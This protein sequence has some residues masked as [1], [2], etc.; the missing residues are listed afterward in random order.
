MGEVTKVRISDYA[1]LK[2]VSWFRD[3]DTLISEDEAFRLYESQWKHLDLSRMNDD[4]RA[5]LDR[6]VDQ[7]GGGVVNA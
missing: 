1:E 3:T 2:S 7:Y 4:E 6:L 5:F